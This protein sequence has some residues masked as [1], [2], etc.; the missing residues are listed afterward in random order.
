MDEI[1]I[2]LESLTISRIT[3]KIS[4]SVSIITIILGV[5]SLAFQRSHNR[6]SVMPYCNIIKRNYENLI[7]IAIVN[8]G[9]GPMI[10]KHIDTKDINDKCKKLNNTYPIDVVP[11]DIPYDT[12]LR[13]LENTTIAS[14]EEKILLK[15]IPRA[16]GDEYSVKQIRDALSQKKL[17]IKYSDIYG[18]K[19]T[20]EESLDNYKQ[21]D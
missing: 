12:F 15:Y 6:K 7:E 20:K 10:I 11:H 2:L 19:I 1:G 18:Q 9:L 16:Y 17:I 3:L 5:L 4:I 8:S 21:K 13:G 14:S